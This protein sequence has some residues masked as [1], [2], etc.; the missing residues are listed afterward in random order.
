M[1]K[2][3]FLAIAGE[4]YDAL[5]ALNKLDNFYDYEKGFVA[6]MQDL[7]RE[8]LENNIGDLSADKRKKKEVADHGRRNHHQ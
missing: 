5:Q 2:E 6:I 8:V 1:T 3:E 7:S 4:R